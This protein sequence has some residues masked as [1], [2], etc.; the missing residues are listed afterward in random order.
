MR[1]AVTER[2]SVW[3]RQHGI[4]LGTS[5]G[6]VGSVTASLWGDRSAP[7]QQP[8]G[9][10]DEC[11]LRLG[12]EVT[13]MSR[14][15]G[16]AQPSSVPGWIRSPPRDPVRSPLLG[17]C[18]PR[19]AA[20]GSSLA[21]GGL[22]GILG[23][24]LSSRR[25]LWRGKK[26]TFQH[27]QI[28]KMD[29]SQ[30]NRDSEHVLFPEREPGKQRGRGWGRGERSQGGGGSWEPGRVRDLDANPTGRPLAV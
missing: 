16:A 18:P 13:G 17:P 27:L 22:R 24:P 26:N 19:W 4:A 25:A 11:L 14:S 6:Q 30:G 8:D 28:L 2:G 1:P 21:G 12:L 3:W 20:P 29:F 7:A 23:A 5:A 10:A 9:R 15:L